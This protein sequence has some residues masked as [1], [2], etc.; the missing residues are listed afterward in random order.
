VEAVLAQDGPRFE[1]VYVNDGSTDETAA[2]LDRRAAE[3]ATLRVI[4]TGNRGPGAA[5]NTAARTARGAYL[6]FLDDDAVPPPGWLDA[7]LAA[8]Q[9][10]GCR[11]LCGGIA[12]YALDTPA[13]RYLHHRM[14]RS[15]GTRPRTLR[16]APSGNLLVERA[17][18]EHVGGF[19]EARWGAAEDWDL[20]L[21]LRAAGAEIVYDP[22]ATVRHRYQ[23]AWPAAR[24][25]VLAMGRTGMVMTRTRGGNPHAYAA[26]N[27]VRWAASPVWAAWRYPPALYLAALR[28]ETAFITARLREYLRPGRAG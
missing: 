6:L 21:R 14:Q 10:H 8:R 2:L 28:M 18:F 27:L 25:R 12:P 1:A 22:A 11:V 9:R 24:E 4:H 17:L 23:R 5:R 3:S 20:C 15:L 26:L 7:M 16:A 19:A 13:E